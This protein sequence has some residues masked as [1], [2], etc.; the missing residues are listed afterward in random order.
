MVAAYGTDPTIPNTSAGP[1]AL[2][3]LM[4]TGKVEF[5]YQS[6]AIETWLKLDC[7]SRPD[8][9]AV[10]N[11]MKTL[12]GVIATYIRGGQPLPAHFGRAIT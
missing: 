5:S 8:R 2:A 3:P 1:D 7:N 10:A 6:T 4:A 12:P 11:V 9:L